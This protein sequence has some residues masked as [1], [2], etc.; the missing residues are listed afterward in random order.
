MAIPSTKRGERSLSPTWKQLAI[1]CKSSSEIK[2]NDC[3]ALVSLPVSFSK[4]KT[5]EPPEQSVF[6]FYHF[7]KENFS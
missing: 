3:M 2:C 4:R 6:A 1:K 7:I 5:E